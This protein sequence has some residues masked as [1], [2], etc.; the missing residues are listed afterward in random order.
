MAMSAAT[1]ATGIAGGFGSQSG[2]T[3]HTGVDLDHGVFKA[4]RIQGKL[5]VA[6]AFDTHGGDDAEG[7]RTKH[8]VFFVREGHSRGDNNAVAGVDAHRIEVFHGA[9]G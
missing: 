6:A 2:G 5:A 8:L 1:L 3:G 4:V 7:R 9:D